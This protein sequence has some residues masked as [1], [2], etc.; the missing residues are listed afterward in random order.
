MF[1]SICRELKH[2]LPVISARCSSE[3]SGKS[4]IKRIWSL[5]EALD[6]VTL[7]KALFLH[8]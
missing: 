7:S 8:V 4:S 6:V 1:S 3:I 2:I 5:D